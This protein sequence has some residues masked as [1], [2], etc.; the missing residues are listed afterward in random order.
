VDRFRKKYESAAAQDK[1][2][3]AEKKV[4]KKKG[5]AKKGEAKA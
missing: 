5:G 1:K 2:I 4:D 3:A